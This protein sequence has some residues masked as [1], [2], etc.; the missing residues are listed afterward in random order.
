MNA[1]HAVK[2]FID[3]SQSSEPA[4]LDGEWQF[5]YGKFIGPQS[6]ENL[7]DYLIIP[8]VWNNHPRAKT[9]QDHASG[10]GFATFRLKVKL[11]QSWQNMAIKIPIMSSAYRL[12]ID[13]RLVASNGKVSQTPEGA[14][15]ENRPQLVLFQR[16]AEKE[17]LSILVHVSN[18]HI[19]KGGIRVSLYLGT[20]QAMLERERRQ[21]GLDLIVFGS[22]FIIAVYHFFLF[23][24][25]REEKSLIYFALLCLLV[26][27]RTGLT[28][29]RAL[30]AMAPGLLSWYAE[31][32]AD[33]LI[34]SVAPLIFA[35]FVSALYAQY[36]SRWYV[37]VTALVSG[38][39]TLTVLA[40]PAYIY[41]VVAQYLLFGYLLL[42]VYTLYRLTWLALNRVSGS[43][44][45]LVGFL[46]LFAAFIN[47]TLYANEVV[48]TFRAVPLGL[49]SFIL[50]Q[51]ILLSSKFNREYRKMQRMSKSMARFVP[52]DFLKILGRESIEDV[53]LGDQTERTM[54]VLFSDLRDFTRL[55]ESMTPAENFAFLNRLLERL[56]PVIRA[57]NGFVDKYIGDAIMA[58]FP[59]GADDAV[60]AALAMQAEL[61][62]YNTEQKAI[63]RAPVRMGIGINTGKLMLGTVGETERIEGTVISDAVNLASRLESESKNFGAAILISDATRRALIRRQQFVLHKLGKVTVKGKT[64]PTP[65]FAVESGTPGVSP[66]SRNSSFKGTQG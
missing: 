3:L 34:V 50:S 66:T 27:I 61:A 51:A 55:S 15:P 46:A 60:A 10:F 36:L 59:A 48:N 41:A 20:E 23:V 22:I 14:V 47:D 13:D 18:Y 62:R 37:R 6:D 9:S 19:H 57:H 63:R 25:R 44:T 33:F 11:P 31:T 29:E 64:K 8:G 28:G 16:T 32:R 40:T 42:G 21:H 2:G 38:A 58:L 30:T 49:L 5:A 26:A 52:V 35:L 1:S 24:L 17:F 54:T 53:E 43:K 4:H 39:V 12:W 56:G 65:V 7:N 45:F